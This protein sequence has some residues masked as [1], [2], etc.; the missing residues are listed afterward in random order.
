LFT[1]YVIMIPMG[2]GPLQ[3]YPVMGVLI[4][5]N[6][7]VAK[8]SG[9][10]AEK[11]VDT[12]SA[13]GYVSTADVIGWDWKINDPITHDTYIADSVSYFIKSVDGKKYQMYFTGYDGQTAGTMTFKVKTVE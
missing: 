3:P 5:P 12:Q 8:V 11:A 9:V 2:P 6:V 13:N 10:A 1:R 4:N 7:T